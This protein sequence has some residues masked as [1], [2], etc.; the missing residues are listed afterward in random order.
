MVLQADPRV[1]GRPVDGAYYEAS[2]TIVIRRSLLRDPERAVLVV[3]HEAVHASGL[4]GRREYMTNELLDRE[5]F[6]SWACRWEAARRLLEAAARG[7][8]EADDA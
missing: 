4:D 7:V 8:S 1:G 2:R 5:A 3:L 6:R